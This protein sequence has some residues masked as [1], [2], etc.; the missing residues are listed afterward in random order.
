[1][2]IYMGNLILG[3]ILQYMVSASF[4]QTMS[5]L[6]YRGSLKRINDYLAFREPVYSTEA[7]FLW[8]VCKP[9]TMHGPS[10]IPQMIYQGDHIILC[11]LKENC[12]LDA[13]P[14]MVVR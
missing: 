2:G 12:Y 13:C 8:G 7:Q 10:T 6:M 4:T 11:M 14:C 9:D 5:Y 1:M 3:T